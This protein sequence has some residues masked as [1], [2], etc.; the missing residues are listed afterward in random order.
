[1]LCNN[2]DPSKDENPDELIV[3]AGIGKAARNWDCFDAMVSTLLK[4]ENDETML[5]QSG[6]PV[7]MIKTHEHAPRELIANSNLVG[8]WDL[9]RLPE[10]TDQYGRHK[11]RKLQN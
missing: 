10:C 5:V 2:L 9:G 7:G 4:L 6:K 1:M 8:N 11:R 3:Y